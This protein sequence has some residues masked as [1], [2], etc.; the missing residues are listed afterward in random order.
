[1]G[2]RWA[3]GRWAFFSFGVFG[4]QWAGDG[5]TMGFFSLLACLAFGGRMMDGRWAFF[6][7]GG[8]GFRWVGDGLFAL[9]M[10]LACSKKC[11]A[12]RGVEKRKYF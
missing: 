9:L 6:S 7:F 11:L 5:R 1:M 8:V 4:F 3:G 10:G 2:G 12:C